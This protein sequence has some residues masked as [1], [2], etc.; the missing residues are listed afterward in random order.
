MMLVNELLKS[1]DPNKSNPARRI[2][3]LNPIF[4]ISL[5]TDAPTQKISS[6]LDVSPHLLPSSKLRQPWK[7]DHLE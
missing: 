3:F 5:N 4:V 6:I 2:S 7:M 1:C